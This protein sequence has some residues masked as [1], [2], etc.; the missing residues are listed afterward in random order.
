MSEFGDSRR[1]KVLL[2]GSGGMVPTGKMLKNRYKL[3]HSESYFELFFFFYL[4]LDSCS[5]SI[6]SEGKPFST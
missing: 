5:W 4:F 3:V 6:I 2:G 1:H